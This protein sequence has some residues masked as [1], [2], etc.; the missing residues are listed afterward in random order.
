MGLFT[1]DT[2]PVKCL[3]GQMILPDLSVYEG[4]QGGSQSVGPPTGGW[5]SFEG[6]WSHGAPCGLGEMS[7][8]EGE[9]VTGCFGEGGWCSGPGTRVFVIETETGL[10]ATTMASMGREQSKHFVIQEI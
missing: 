2:L 4:E 7:G 9:C 1:K 10:K 5:D 8:T 3:S 6:E